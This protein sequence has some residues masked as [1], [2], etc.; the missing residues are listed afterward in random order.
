MKKRRSLLQVFAAAMIVLF[1]CGCQAEEIVPA[2]P[3]ASPALPPAP[4]ATPVL[5]WA[6]EDVAAEGMAALDGS[7]IVL[8]EHKGEVPIPNVSVQVTFEPTG[9]TLEQEAGCLEPGSKKALCFWC[10]D[11]NYAPADFAE[12]SLKVTCSDKESGFACGESRLQVNKGQEG[13]AVTLKNTGKNIRELEA[14]AVFWKGSEPVG[15]SPANKKT[16]LGAGKSWTV[17]FLPP[18]DGQSRPM[19][20]DRYEVYITRAWTEK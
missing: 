10:V 1:L 3:A 5:T 13:T 8:L 17:E 19:E 14:I 4:T 6:E 12:A 18:I 2:G 16:D 7:Y 11:E 9:V 20:Y 15:C